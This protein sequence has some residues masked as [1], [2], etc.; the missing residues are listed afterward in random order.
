MPDYTFTAY[1]REL[2]SRARELR[3]SMTRQERHLWYDF[4]RDYPVKF[5]RQRVIER[6][7]VD[8][9]CSQARLIIELDGSQHFMVDGM[10]RDSLRSDMLKAHNL[11][12]LRFAN[13]DVDNNFE[14]VCNMIDKTVQECC[15][16]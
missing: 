14:G 1:N 8:F 3:K 10:I 11:Q 15:H 12:I 5:Y 4:L 9:Y 2:K 7:I 6:F 13:C 16:R